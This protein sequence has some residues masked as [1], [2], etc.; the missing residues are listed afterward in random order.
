MGQDVLLQWVVKVKEPEEWQKERQVVKANL[1]MMNKEKYK[2][3]VDALKEGARMVIKSKYL[4]DFTQFKMRQLE[5]TNRE[6]N[7]SL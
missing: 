4:R 7:K 1:D 5:Q 3:E 2:I 6:N